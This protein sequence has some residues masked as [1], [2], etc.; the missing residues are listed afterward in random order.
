MSTYR[1]PVS[2]DRNFGINPLPDR[3]KQRPWPRMGATLEIA[4]P[5]LDMLIRL[6]METGKS[7][8]AII[9]CLLVYCSRQDDDARMKEYI[10]LYA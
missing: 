5:V 4:P 2:P 10:E 1:D 3:M 6:Q 7:Q 8:Q 9:A